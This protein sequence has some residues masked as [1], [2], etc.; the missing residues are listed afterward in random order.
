MYKTDVEAHETIRN[1]GLVSYIDREKL[2][3]LMLQQEFIQNIASG[4]MFISGEMVFQIILTALQ[5]K[6][7][8]IFLMK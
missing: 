1:C 2:D 8:H 7:Y 3:Q 6:N 5:Q 4:Q